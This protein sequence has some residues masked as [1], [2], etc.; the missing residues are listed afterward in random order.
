MAAPTAHR[1]VTGGRR[2]RRRRPPRAKRASPFPP[3]PTRPQFTRAGRGVELN[4]F[5]HGGNAPKIAETNSEAPRGEKYRRLFASAAQ[6]MFG[7][8]HTRVRGDCYWDPRRTKEVDFRGT[9]IT[10]R[11]RAVRDS[12]TCVGGAEAV[13]VAWWIRCPLPNSEGFEPP[14]EEGKMF[15]SCPSTAEVMGA[16]PNSCV[17][18]AR[19]LPTQVAALLRSPPP[20]SEKFVEQ[21]S[22]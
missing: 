17:R 10:S 3:S 14:S 12:D 9:V 22:K 19:G 18:N 13:R 6:E 5:R 16:D 8:G 11:D 15:A 7:G 4:R 2:R 1:D 20:C 21:K